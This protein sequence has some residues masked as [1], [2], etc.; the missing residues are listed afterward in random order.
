M[1]IDKIWVLA[2]VVDGSATNTTL[3]L[4]TEARSIG[5]TPAAVNWVGVAGGL[6]AKSDSLVITNVVGLTVDGDDVRSEHGLFG[7]AQVAK[8]RFT[9]ERPWIFVVRAKS[10][11]AESAG[12]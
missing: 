1:S 4:L 2:E 6:S 10:F 12:G 8:A 7:G 9:G 5:S 11:A 3:E